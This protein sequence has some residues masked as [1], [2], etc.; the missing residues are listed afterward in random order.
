MDIQIGEDDTKLS[1]GGKKKKKA[2]GGGPSAL[3]KKKLQ[4]KLGAGEGNGDKEES[5]EETKAVESKKEVEE[6]IIVYNVNEPEKKLEENKESV[7][8]AEEV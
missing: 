4:L 2:S 6:T 8:I 7:K 3:F 5:K 1:K